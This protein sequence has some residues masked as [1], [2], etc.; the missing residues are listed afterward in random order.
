MEFNY[1][2]LRTMACKSVTDETIRGIIEANEI[3][4]KR[5]NKTINETLVLEPTNRHYFCNECGKYT[6]HVVEVVEEEDGKIFQH[7]TCECGA[8]DKTYLGR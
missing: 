6:S 1:E 2:N 8:I 7:S 5:E 3:N 4:K